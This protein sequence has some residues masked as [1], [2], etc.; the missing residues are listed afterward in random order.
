MPEFVNYSSY[1]Y[2]E[3]NRD[4]TA[5]EPDVDSIGIPPTWQFYWVNMETGDWFFP[6]SREPDSRTWLKVVNSSNIAEMIP[7][8]TWSI[9]SASVA[10]NSPRTP[11]STENV[12]VVASF[13]Q[14]S[15]LLA[16]S[17]VQVQL[18]LGE[19]WAVIGTVSLSGLVT[20]QTNSITFDVPKG[21][22]YR[23]ISVSGSNSVVSTV[24][25][26]K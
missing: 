21:V 14:T 8:S 20:T 9:A 16:S 19:K 24:E 11:S 1:I 12:S 23:Y 26:R 7:E 4:P 25:T 13:S 22:E 2:F 5:D 6:F 15:T 3:D 17:V 18:K 10:F